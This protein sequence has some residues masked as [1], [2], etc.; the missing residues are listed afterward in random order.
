MRYRILLTLCAFFSL[1]VATAQKKNN[2]AYAITSEKQGQFVWT[3]VKLIDLNTGQVLQSVFENNRSAYQVYNARTGNNI[4][5][6]DDK[7]MITSKQKQPFATYS[8]AA[9]FDKKHNRLY[10]TPMFINELRYIDLNAKSPK[11]YYFEGETFSNATNLNLSLIH[12]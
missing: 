12:I 6:K 5:V 10:Y 2:I 8:A 9:A 3:E 11:L 1:L 7:G 4:Q